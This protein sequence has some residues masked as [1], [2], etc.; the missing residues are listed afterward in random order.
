MVL[1]NGTLV[2]I[3]KLMERIKAAERALLDTEQVVADLK[4]ENGDLVSVNSKSQSKIKDLTSDVNSVTKKLDSMAGLQRK[5][6][7]YLSALASINDKITPFLAKK[8]REKD[9][10]KERSV[11]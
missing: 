11:S 2:N 9:R 6:S 3:E 10:E 4:K 7:E 5:N 8:E 1:H